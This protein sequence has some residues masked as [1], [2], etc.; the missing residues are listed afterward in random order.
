MKILITG[1]CGFV[2]SNIA[3]FLKKNLR[4][5]DIFSVDN[6]F[7]EGSKI[8][9]N[10]LKNFNIKNYNFDIKNYNKVKALKKCDLIIDCCA[11]PAIEASSKDPDRVFETNL[12]GT[13]NLMKKS[14]KDNANIIF[15]SSSRVYSISNLRNLSSVLPRSTPRKKVIYDDFGEP[16]REVWI[17]K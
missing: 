17:E 10:R 1:G 11:E 4:K 14:K 16:L 8:N 2:G 3:I 5:A 9:K 13:F 15:L 7:R 12:I 6:L